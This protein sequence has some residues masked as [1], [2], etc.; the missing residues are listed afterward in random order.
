MTIEYLRF[1]VLERSQDLILVDGD[2]EIRYAEFVADLLA[3]PRMPRPRISR[4]AARQFGR[5]RLRG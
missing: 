3:I 1:H 5:D 4:A 2:R